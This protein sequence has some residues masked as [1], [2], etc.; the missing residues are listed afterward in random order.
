ME[1]V[2][3]LI[4]KHL[5]IIRA[6]IAGMRDDIREIELGLSNVEGGI[7]DLKRDTADL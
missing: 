7:G 5:R 1:N 4:L 6:N 2:N 3:N